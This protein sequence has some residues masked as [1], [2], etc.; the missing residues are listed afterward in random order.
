MTQL[1]SLHSTLCRHDRG[2]QSHKCILLLLT[3]EFSSLLF[4]WCKRSKSSNSDCENGGSYWEFWPMCDSRCRCV[5]CRAGKAGSIWHLDF[6]P[7]ICCVLCRNIEDSLTLFEAL[8]PQTSA[9][10]IWSEHIQGVGVIDNLYKH[11]HTSNESQM[12]AKQMQ[13]TKDSW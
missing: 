9:A 3:F 1:F 4:S 13:F 11:T 2:V 12:S 10:V 6:E 7:F 5:V 8:D